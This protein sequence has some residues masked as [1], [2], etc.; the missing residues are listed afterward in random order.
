MTLH[1]LLGLPRACVP[2]GACFNLMAKNVVV[3]ATNGK[4]S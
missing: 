4:V 3:A 2:L 1:S